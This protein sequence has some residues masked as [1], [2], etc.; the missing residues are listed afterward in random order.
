MSLIY[1]ALYFFFFFFLIGYVLKEIKIQ[2]Y[3]G[4]IVCKHEHL[5]M[6]RYFVDATLF[7][8]FSQ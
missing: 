1:V 2:V 7:A 6:N 8:F 3:S 5:L 4:I